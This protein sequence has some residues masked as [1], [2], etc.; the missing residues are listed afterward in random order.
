MM[1]LEQHITNLRAA[2]ARARAEKQC[3]DDTPMSR[4]SDDRATVRYFRWAWAT[5]VME[6][7]QE[8]EQ[9]GVSVA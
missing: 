6:I 3:W 1:T 2:L 9:A 8:L 5:N 7:E 4:A